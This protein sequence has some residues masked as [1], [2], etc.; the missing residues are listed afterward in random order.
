[1]IKRLAIGLVLGLVMGGIVGAV[2]EQ[3]LGVSFAGTAGAFFAY[4]FSA[5]TGVLTGLIAGKPIWSQTG[6]IEAGLKAGFGGLIAAGLM[7]AIRKFAHIEVPAI[8]AALHTK[9]AFI[10]SF[11]MLTLPMIA[12]ALGTFFEADNTPDEDDA[13]A[14]KKPAAKA[15]AK[16]APAKA[17]APAAAAAKGKAAEK[18]PAP[19]AKV[20]VEP[21]KKQKSLMEELEEDD[22]LAAAEAAK[23]NAH[24]R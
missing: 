24:K 2:I 23:E 12:G 1:M 15:E 21:A 7:L 4:S 11:P 22:A 19:A 20:R 3:A 5:L 13:K 9:D 16:A 17:V 10:D 18:T 14:A 6:K 8:A